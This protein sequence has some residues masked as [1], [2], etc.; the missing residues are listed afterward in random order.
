ESLAEEVRVTV[1]ATGFTNQTFARA[2]KQMSQLKAMAEAQNLLTQ[3]MHLTKTASYSYQ[4]TVAAPPVEQ[5]PEPEA[6]A[7]MAQE[8]VQAPVVEDVTKFEGKPEPPKGF[9]V[10]PETIKAEPAKFEVSPS[11]EKRVEYP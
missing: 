6:E 11:S 3:Q 9:D 1:I 10:K 4:P 5:P 8:E 7:E 2:D